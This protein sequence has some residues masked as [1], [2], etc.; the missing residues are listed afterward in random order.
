MNSVILS[1][2]CQQKSSLTWKDSKA[3][4]SVLMSDMQNKP[5]TPELVNTRKADHDGESTCETRL[6]LPALI[7][8]NVILEIGPMCRMET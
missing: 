3:Q 1:A 7:E 5:V 2:Y 8:I 6:K 4:N